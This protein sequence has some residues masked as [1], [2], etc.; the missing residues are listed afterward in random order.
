MAAVVLREGQSVTE[1]TLIAYCKGR[2]ASYKKPQ[3]IYFPSDAPRSGT[4]D[5]VR[6]QL[7]ERF[8]FNE[9]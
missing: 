4:G 6:K 7:R 1:E 2:L 5:I 3:K 9:D 8:T